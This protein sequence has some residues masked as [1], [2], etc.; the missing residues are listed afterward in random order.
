MSER[1]ESI[2]CFWEN[3]LKQKSF[4]K[5]VTNF[6]IETVSAGLLLFNLEMV[7]NSKII[8]DGLL[9]HSKHLLKK[10]AKIYPD[11]LKALF[12]FFRAGACNFTQARLYTSAKSKMPI[13]IDFLWK[14]KCKNWGK[15]NNWK[16]FLW[17]LK[18]CISVKHCESLLVLKAMSHF[19]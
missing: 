5:S 7:E 11:F 8:L 13:F 2:L 14:M 17:H 9:W 1:I 3:Y 19:E 12:T 6:A 15:S 16:V 10:T 18:I 4:S